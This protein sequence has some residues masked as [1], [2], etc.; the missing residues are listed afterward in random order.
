VPAEQV[1]KSGPIHLH[2]LLKY[3]SLPISQKAFRGQKGR[4]NTQTIILH[5]YYTPKPTEFQDVL[6]IFTIFVDYDDFYVNIVMLT[7]ETNNQI[8][9]IIFNYFA[10]CCV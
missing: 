10:R 3:I 8:I 4:K 2:N 1:K 9:F 7:Q 5:K 6:S